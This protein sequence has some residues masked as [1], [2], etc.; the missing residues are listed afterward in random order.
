MW[1][2]EKE[3]HDSTRW[4]EGHYGSDEGT[5]FNG[6][7]LILPLNESD[8]FGMWYLGLLTLRLRRQ[9]RLEDRL[10]C[11]RVCRRRW[12]SSREIG[13]Q[14]TLSGSWRRRCLSESILTSN[15]DRSRVQGVV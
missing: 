2:R 10:I 6:D 14:A 12:P 7:G 4:M 11:N 15:G 1:S 9:L 8:R 3:G 13:H 5:S